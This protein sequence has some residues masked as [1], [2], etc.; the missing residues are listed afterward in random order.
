MIKGMKR[1][2]FSCPLYAFVFQLYFLL[3]LSDFEFQIWFYIIE[4]I[5]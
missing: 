3:W 5:I 2:I 4:F 1:V